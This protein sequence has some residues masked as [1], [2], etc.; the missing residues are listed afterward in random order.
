MDNPEERRFSFTRVQRF[1]EISVIVAAVTTVPIVALQ[2]FGQT[3]VAIVAIDWLLWAVFVVDLFVGVSY[4]MHPRLHHVLNG[5]I[6]VTSFPLL[7]D[8]LSVT[9]LALLIRL[10]RVILVIAAIGRATP[11]LRA[12]VGRTGFLYIAGLV[13]FVVVS[14]ASILTIVEPETADFWG[15]IWWALVTITTVGYGDIAP[16][17]PLGRLIGAALMI[18]G[19]SLVATLSATI[20]AYF[21][22]TDADKRLER[23]E[24]RLERLD[25]SLNSER[26]DRK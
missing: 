1:L 23:I 6:V 17:S 5:V 12:T 3:S 16:V 25:H 2:H 14:G 15:A 7:P 18:C 10:F 21:V 8:L 13:L 11:A 19:I 22:G 4:G 26:Q 24:E 9:R 20:A